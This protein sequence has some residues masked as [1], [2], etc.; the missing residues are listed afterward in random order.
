MLRLTTLDGVIGACCVGVSLLVPA[1]SMPLVDPAYRAGERIYFGDVVL[2]FSAGNVVDQLPHGL[3]ACVHCHSAS[4]ADRSG[5]PARLRETKQAPTLTA[6][7]LLSEKSR[8]GGPPFAFDRDGFCAT[9]RSGID[10]QAIILRK[11]MPRFNATEEQCDSLW[12]FLT[13]RLANEPSR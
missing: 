8:R 2:Q 3:S 12:Y 1:A 11:T 4:K 7:S 13:R 10:P 6:A 9:I 5:F